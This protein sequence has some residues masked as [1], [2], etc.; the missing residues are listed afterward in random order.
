[1]R[2]TPSTASGSKERLAL[3]ATLAAVLVASAVFASAWAPF[4]GAAPPSSP[5]AH[6]KIN[7]NATAGQMEGVFV[8]FKTP[9]ADDILQDFVSDGTTFFDAVS[10]GGYEKRD[11]L[12]AGAE[13]LVHGSNVDTQVHDNPNALVKFTVD[14]G[15]TLSFNL[16]AGLYAD[17]AGNHSAFNISVS[18]SNRTA[19]V[20]WHCNNTNGTLGGGGHSFEVAAGSTCHVFFRSHVEGPPSELAISGAAEAGFLMAEIRVGGSSD[21][22]DVATYG[23]TS[24]VVAHTL[25]GVAVSLG[26]EGNRPSSV[27]IR[28]TPDDDK[29]LLVFVDGRAVRMADG[30]QDALNPTDDGHDIEFSLSPNDDGTA[31]LVVSVPDQAS[32]V[33]Q[34]KA[35][36]VTVQPARDVT[37]A[38]AGV[39]VALA[40]TAGA[41][42][43]LFRRR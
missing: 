40:I 10:A 1:M 19:T 25:E 34:I 36:S 41:A 26:P 31:L 12:V 16:G 3:R 22:T 29:E 21:E 6:G 24:V 42:L 30:L 37:P 28:F 23:E 7:L 38:V 27:V 39:V 13:L 18:G 43:I 9:A 8:Q 35:A 4:A 2:A 33:V 15:T 17:W 20:W 14:N 32:H 5:P 11:E